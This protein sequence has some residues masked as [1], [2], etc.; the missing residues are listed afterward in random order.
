M[1]IPY[2]LFKEEIM[3]RNPEAEYF[4]FRPGPL[5]VQVPVNQADMD[6]FHG[7]LVKAVWPEIDELTAAA[8]RSAAA[9]HDIW[10]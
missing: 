8:N 9:A 6:A 7:R 4:G 10:F 2:P 1:I 5:A 3:D